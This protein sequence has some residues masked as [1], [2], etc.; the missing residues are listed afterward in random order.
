MPHRIIIDATPDP[1]VN[2]Y[3]RLSGLT[4]LHI[5][6]KN[7]QLDGET[8]SDGYVKPD[9][10]DVEIYPNVIACIKRG[11]DVNG[12]QRGNTYTPLDFFLYNIMCGANHED[13]S[14]LVG[15]AT[16]LLENGAEVKP[17]ILG[18]LL[19][20]LAVN[21]FPAQLVTIDL[22]TKNALWMCIALC[23]HHGQKVIMSTDDLGFCYFNNFKQKISRHLLDAISHSAILKQYHLAID[24]GLIEDAPRVTCLE[25]I[26]QTF[27]DQ[28]AATE[29]AN[30]SYCCVGTT[31]EQMHK[32]ALTVQFAMLR[33]SA[34]IKVAARKEIRKEEKFTDQ[35]MAVANWLR[36]NFS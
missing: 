7:L 3:D 4:P 19:A 21:R 34:R 31:V 28:V 20:F 24:Q 16:V 23:M 33:N 10:D 26:G 9:S 5:A 12:H 30:L 35:S 18:D 36:L 1:N 25:D 8:Y 17:F 6:I 29:A 11:A 15:I 14:I 13:P 22:Q 27:R 2:K 32:A